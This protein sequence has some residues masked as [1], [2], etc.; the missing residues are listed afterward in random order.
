MS[1]TEREQYAGILVEQTNRL[2]S[3][4]AVDVSG[5]ARRDPTQKPWNTLSPV[6]RLA[7]DAYDQLALAEKSITNRVNWERTKD[8]DGRSGDDLMKLLWDLLKELGVC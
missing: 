5:A 4:L 3:I 1:S 8:K 2:L 7:A 6:F